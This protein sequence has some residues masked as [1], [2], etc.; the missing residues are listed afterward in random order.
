M[1]SDLPPVT[2]TWPNDTGGTKLRGYVQLNNGTDPG[3]LNPTLADNTIAPAAVHYMGPVII[4]QRDR[5]V[6]VKFTNMLPTGQGGHLFIP[7]DT[8]VMGEQGTP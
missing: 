5:P 8:T 7:V 1:H 4:A 2:G 3:V 6:R